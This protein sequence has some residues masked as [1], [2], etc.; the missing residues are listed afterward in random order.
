MVVE[1]YNFSKRPNSTKLP[2]GT[3]VTYHVN[4]IDTTSIINPKFSLKL[5][6]NETFINKNYAYIP[7]FGRYYFITDISY[8]L[9]LWII[10][11]KCD[12]L[13][14]A[15]AQIG[16][17]MQYVI[18]SASQFD[19]HVIDKEYPTKTNQTYELVKAD[20]TIY[21]T[22]VTPWF[23]IGII[24]GANPEDDSVVSQMYNGSVV[25]YGCT[26]AQLYELVY[27]LLGSVNLYNIPSSEISE[28]LQK[29]LINPIQYVHSIKCVPFTPNF[30]QD[31]FANGFYC[32][33]NYVDIKTLADANNPTPQANT[34]E[35]GEENA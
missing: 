19:G 31:K 24:G 13:A 20:R 3:P 7:Y 1:L 21:G 34:N 26:Q 2:T 4:M 12:V 18:R 15:K 28:P 16:A 23:I 5:P 9:G 29:Q 33:F 10:S 11:M 25:Y 6:Q 17:S 30:I 8:D 35:G 14:T 32:G 22:I 27:N